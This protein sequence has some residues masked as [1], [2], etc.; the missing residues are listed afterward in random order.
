MEPC[1]SRMAMC[2]AARAA[3]SAASRTRGPHQDASATYR[4]REYP[5]ECSYWSPTGAARTAFLSLRLK[6]AGAC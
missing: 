2:T 5:P 6:I 1:S 3:R 4:V